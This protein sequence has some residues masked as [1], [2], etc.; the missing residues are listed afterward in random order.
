MVKET[1]NGWF[2]KFNQSK[3]IL[4]TFTQ[5]EI[6][7]G[8]IC[9]FSPCGVNDISVLPG[10]SLIATAADGLSTATVTGN[11]YYNSAPI[12]IKNMI[13]VSEQQTASININNIAAIDTNSSSINATTWLDPRIQ[14]S[15]NNITGGYFE[16]IKT[17]SKVM[18]FNQ[19]QILQGLYLYC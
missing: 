12:I 16:N 11:V 15:I 5:G 17:Q 8:S 19:S 6:N 7:Q 14:F 1:N 13:T 18:S 4:N 10:F 9:F 2:A 3:T